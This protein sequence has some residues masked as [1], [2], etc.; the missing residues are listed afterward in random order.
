MLLTYTYTKKVF[1]SLLPI[2]GAKFE[3]SLKT[4]KYFCES[5]HSKKKGEK[6]GFEEAKQL[7]G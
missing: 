6:I 5:V 3:F 1:F 4:K 2:S 7:P